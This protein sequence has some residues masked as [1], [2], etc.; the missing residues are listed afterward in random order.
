[1]RRLPP[2]WIPN[3]HGA[4]AMITVPVLL[5]VLIGG[6]VWQHLLLLGLWW[7]GYFAFY[8]GGLW[9]R[10]RRRP[11]YLPPVRAYTLVTLVFGVGLLIAAPYLLRWLPL[12][13]PLIATTA[14][15]SSHRKDRSLLNDAVTVTAATLTLPVAFDLATHGL[16]TPPG[17]SADASLTGWGWVWLVTLVVGWY[18]L[19]TVFY[20]KTN[21]RE[22]GKPTWYIASVV[23]H[24]V[25]LVGVLVLAV[26]GVVTWPLAALWLIIAV[27]AAA[28]PAWGYYRRWL[29]ALTIGLGEMVISAALFV[30]VLI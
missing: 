5:G 21:I 10:S 18:F 22:R 17:A 24:S 28:V 12:F 3:Y 13:I 4:W 20:V 27:R 23:F 7:A 30:S 15:A 9:L 26:L 19:G 11:R 6:F 25:G 2:G 8:A 1:M 14:W 16:A 29:P